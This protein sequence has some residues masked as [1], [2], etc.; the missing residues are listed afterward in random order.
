M[1]IHAK[2]AGILYIL[3]SA[4]LRHGIGNFPR[5]DGRQVSGMCF[6]WTPRLEHHQHA[7]TVAGRQDVSDK[8]ATKRLI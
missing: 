8:L 7:T 3:Y 1:Y 4:D 6:I 5:Q 2:Y